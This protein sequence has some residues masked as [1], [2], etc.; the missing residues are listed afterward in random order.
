MMST[1]LPKIAKCEEEVRNWWV[2][3]N[4]QERIIA[5]LDVVYE[6][7]SIFGFP[8]PGG[9]A[10]KPWKWAAEAYSKHIEESE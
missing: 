3:L 2:E 9:V 6:N 4:D 8:H 10:E 1:D 7:A 5:A